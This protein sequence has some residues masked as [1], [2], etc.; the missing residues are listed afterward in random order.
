MIPQSSQAIDFTGAWKNDSKGGYLIKV[1]PF[2]KT[3]TIVYIIT[4]I[5]SAYIIYTPE[6]LHCAIMQGFLV[7]LGLIF[8]I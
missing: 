3:L 1:A 4:I 8:Y 2:N 6:A 5:Y 7:S